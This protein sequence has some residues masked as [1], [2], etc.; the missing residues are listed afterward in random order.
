LV[1]N[2]LAPFFTALFNRSLAAGHFPD[3]FREASITPILKKPS[4]DSADVRS[5]RP[6]SNLSVVS[7]LLERIVAR[8]LV[9]CLQSSCLLPVFQFGFR[10]GHS[11]E[12]AVLRVMSDLLRAVDSGDYAALVLLDL[13]AAFDIVDHEILLRRLQASFGLDGPV[14]S[15]FRSYL[16]GRSQYVRRGASRSPS[17]RLRCGV[18]QGSVLGPILFILYTAD[19]VGLI[20]QFGFHPHFYADDTQIYGS[21]SKSAVDEFQQRFSACTDDVHANRLQLNTDKTELLWCIPL[22]GDFTNS[23]R[24]RSGSGRTS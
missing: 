11:T 5:Y 12:T 22:R 15:W 17:L 9:L 4:L 21:C 23:R 6:I 20:E 18:P 10:S 13:T 7:K 19:L 2:E 3:V 14:I 1:V 16:P 24:R 8:Q